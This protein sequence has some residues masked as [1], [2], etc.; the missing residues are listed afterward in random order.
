MT[1]ELAD[2]GPRH[3]AQVQQRDSP[4]AQVVPLGVRIVTQPVPLGVRIVTQPVPHSCPNVPERPLGTMRVFTTERPETRGGKRPR[5]S[6]V[7]RGRFAVLL[8]MQKVVGSS[9]SSALSRSPAQAGFSLVSAR[10]GGAAFARRN[11][12]RLGPG[13]DPNAHDASH[14][15]APH[16]P[17]ESQP[18]AL[19]ADCANLDSGGG[20][21]GRRG[22]RGGRA[23]HQ[24]RCE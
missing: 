12:A 11:S 22:R 7:V 15:S 6:C 20:D 13:G 1:D 21:P 3:P 4:V 9:P 24:A 5:G 10:I 16:E 19:V 18:A 8:A 23:S 2:P 17:K 14:N